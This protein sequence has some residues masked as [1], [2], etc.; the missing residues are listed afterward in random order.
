MAPLFQH[1]LRPLRDIVSSWEESN[2]EVKNYLTGWYWLSDGWYCL[3]TDDGDVPLAHSAFVASLGLSG[4]NALYLDYQVARFWMDLVEVVPAALES[5]PEP[6]A[7]WVVS[8]VWPAWVAE[9]QTWWQALDDEDPASSDET[10]DDL[11]AARRWWNARHIDMGYLVAPP[12]LRFWCLGDTVTLQW[13][14]RDRLVEGRPCW[15]EKIGQQEMSVSSFEQEINSFRRRLD[16]DMGSRI[17]EV[18][19]L[20]LLSAEQVAGLWRQ[21]EEILAMRGRWEG[22][23]WQEVKAAVAYLEHLSGI[24]VKACGG[25]QP[26][27]RSFSDGP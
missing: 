12:G 17:Q 16:Q 10:W 21:H 19:S 13:D 3:Q 18:E 7:E 6:F 26:G 20:G 2:F 11:F 9:V 4:E 23:D 22:T 15:V 27:V 24:S 14:T 25:S 1:R 5:L 8:G